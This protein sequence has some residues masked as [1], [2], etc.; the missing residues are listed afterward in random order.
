MIPVFL[1]FK[2]FLAGISRAQYTAEKS[3]RRLVKDTLVNYMYRFA[4]NTNPLL[5]RFV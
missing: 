4:G 3:Y 1:C 5:V 2:Q